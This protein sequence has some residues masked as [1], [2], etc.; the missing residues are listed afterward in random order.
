VVNAKGRTVQ[1]TTF[2]EFTLTDGTTFHGKI[3]IPIQGRLTD[4]LNDER[5]F[6]PIENADGEL[7][8]LAKASIRH[9]S[10]P[11]ADA[12][13]YKGNDPYTILGVQ[14]GV[15]FEELKNAYHQL[16]LVNHPDR[17]RS[18]GLGEDYQELATLNMARINNAYSQVS[19][20]VTT[21]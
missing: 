15:S 2:L 12:A 10:M 4:V 3:F 21:T 11:P 1:K 7:F 5:S 14:Q 20:K 8:V 16:S 13:A 9:I 18:F 6:L 19:K 17:I